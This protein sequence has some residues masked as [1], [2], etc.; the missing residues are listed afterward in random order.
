MSRLRVSNVVYVSVLL[1]LIIGIAL[2]YD[3]STSPY[4]G[5]VE[6]DFHLQVHAYKQDGGD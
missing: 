2:V 4:N 5:V 1:L 6:I 3:Y